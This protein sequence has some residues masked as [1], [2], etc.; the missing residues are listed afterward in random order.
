MGIGLSVSRAIIEA[1][2]GHLWAV[3]N[4][5]PGTT[6]SFSIPCRSGL[7]ADCRT[8]RKPVDSA[9]EAD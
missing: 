9:A 6:F 5:G 1:H 3:A 2:R 4:D 8:A 7:G